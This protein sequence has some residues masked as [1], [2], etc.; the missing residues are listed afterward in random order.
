[1]LGHTEVEINGNKTGVLF[2]VALFAVIE[3]EKLDLSDDENDNM[4]G[5]K[6][7]YAAIKNNCNLE[8]QKCNITLKDVYLFANNEA[9]E[10]KRVLLCFEASKNMGKPI[11]EIAKELT[12]TQEKKK[13]TSL[14]GKIFQKIASVL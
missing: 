3:S 10:Y 12:E 13:K 11:K 6:L 1:M 4:N 8:Q 5:I 9:E 7:V 14:F 2:G